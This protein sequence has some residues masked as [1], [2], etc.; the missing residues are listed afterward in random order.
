M[1]TSGMEGTLFNIVWFPVLLWVYSKSK[2]KKEKTIKTFLF[3]KKKKLQ[4]LPP[5]YKIFD[6]FI[7]LIV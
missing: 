2:K 4:K 1:K 5:F 7:K 6:F 3:L